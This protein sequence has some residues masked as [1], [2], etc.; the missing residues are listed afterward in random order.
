MRGLR[1]VLRRSPQPPPAAAAADGLEGLL[2]GSGQPGLAELRAVL[3]ELLAPGGAGRLVEASELKPR[4]HRLRFAGPGG[5]RRL[6]VKRLDPDVARRNELVAR[7]WLPAVGLAGCGPPLVGVAAERGGRCT[8]HV[9]EDLGDCSLA[10]GEPAEPERVGPAVELIA[11]VHTR[12]AGH[13]LLGE[14]RLWGGDLGMHFFSS[15]VRDALG[16][17]RAL[18]APAVE[19]PP[20]GATLI[21]RLE[22]R[23][24]RLGA[25]EPRRVRAMAAVGGPETLLHGDLW[26]TNTMVLERGAQPRVRLIDWDH[27][28]VGPVSYDLS[29]FLYR[30]GPERRDEVLGRYRDAYGRRGLRLPDRSRLDLLFD[31][32]ECARLANRVIWPA[33]A[34]AEG[35]LEWALEELARV[36]GWFEDLRPVLGA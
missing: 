3:G 35:Q 29:T 26:T 11:D 20:E 10:A 23:L 2:G 27:A 21:E 17:L 28:A 12:F 24:E 31:T 13:R 36:E 18:R 32:A 7:R 33:I 4:V 6:V 8:W 30:F 22:G 25:D 5:T 34:A 19:L 16:A 1:A 9:Y 15:N 14:C